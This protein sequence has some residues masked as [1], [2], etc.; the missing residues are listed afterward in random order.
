MFDGPTS[1]F[2]K[3]IIEAGVAPAFASGVGY[4]M[5]T[6]E[7]T[8]SIGVSNIKVNKENISK[9]EKAIHETLEQLVQDGI[10][11]D[12]FEAQLH[13]L[14][15]KIKK[16]R[17]HWGL[18]TISN[19]NSYT[20]YDGNPLDVFRFNEFSEC[21]RKDFKN[22][23]FQE[24]IKKYLINNQHKLILKMIPDESITEKQQLQELTMLKNIESTLS[25]ED[26]ERLVQEALELQKDQEIVQDIDLLPTLT[27]NDI[28][29][30]IEHVEHKKS[31]LYDSMPVYWFNQPTNGLTHLRIKIDTS[32]LPKDKKMLIPIIL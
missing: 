22:G 31:M 12:Q 26:K 6:K 15:L 25:D 23:I 2:Y 19:M 28:P 32:K 8:F 24:L 9:V 18:M 16:T 17:N 1:A 30:K 20:L 29:A 11:E 13:S 27:L 4:D 21:I 10:P 3:N 5:T 7:G 14:E